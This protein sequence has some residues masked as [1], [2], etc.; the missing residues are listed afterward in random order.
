MKIDINA[1][2]KAVDTAQAVV[3]ER[4]APSVVVAAVVGVVAA[5]VCLGV[6]SAAVVCLGVVSAAVVGLGVVEV[7]V[8]VE[9][10]C[11]VVV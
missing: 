8:V 9:V 3:T 10:D 4:E 7:R 5:V 1:K 6:V 2:R 11:V